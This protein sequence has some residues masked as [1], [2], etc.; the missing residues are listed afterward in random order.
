MVRWRK[1][2][3]TFLKSSRT[4]VISLESKEQTPKSKIHFYKWSE[5]KDHL[6]LGVN[7]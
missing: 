1:L 6:D 5:N 2:Y 7:E 3:I 4:E